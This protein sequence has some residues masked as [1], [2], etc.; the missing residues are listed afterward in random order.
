M[1]ETFFSYLHIPGGKYVLKKAY[2]YVLPYSAEVK[3]QKG[4]L[5]FYDPPTVESKNY[6]NWIAVLDLRTCPKCRSNHGQIYCIGELPEEM[7]PLHF[8][9]RCEIKPM[10]AVVAGFAAKN[11]KDGADWWLKHFEKLLDYY[12]TADELSELGWKF[13]DKPSKF[14]PGKMLTAG[15]YENNNGHLPQKPGRIWY[16]ADINYTPGVRNKHRILWSNDGLIFVTY[17]HYMT[18]YEI[19]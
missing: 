7:P 19:L 14:A 2:G 13:G 4:R 15:I 5:D 12:I 1:K 18:F 9:C 11:G 10:K 3:I 16:E 8:Y 17:D 6:T